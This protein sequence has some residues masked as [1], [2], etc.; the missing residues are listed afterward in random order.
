MTDSTT[1][2]QLKLARLEVDLVALVLS[3]ELLLDL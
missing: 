1:P 2:L 3:V